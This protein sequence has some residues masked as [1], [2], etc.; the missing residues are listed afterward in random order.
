MKHILRLIVWS[1][2]LLVSTQSALATSTTLYPSDDTYINGNASYV[3]K[4]YGSF[5]TLRVSG[6]P[7]KN[8]AMLFKFP[9]DSLPANKTISSAKF[10]LY[11]RQTLDNTVLQSG[12]ISF[13]PITSAWSQDSVTWS[14]RPSVNIG[15]VLSGIR[16]IVDTDPGYQEWDITPLVQQW[17]DHPDQN[18]GFMIES[19]DVGWSCGL[20]SFEGAYQPKL[21]VQY[22][23]SLP[24]FIKPAI[25]IIPGFIVATP[26]PMPLP[27][28]QPTPSPTPTSTSSP[29]P[30]PTV[31]P[32]IPATPW[33]TTQP[34][35]SPVPTEEMEDVFIPVTKPE[36]A[37]NLPI[38]ILVTVAIFCL[39]GVI[40][41]ITLLRKRKPYVRTAP[42]KQR[43]RK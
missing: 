33:P 3:F 34:N 10:K 1:F 18:F 14:N 7:Q 38:M 30:T 26:T 9:V 20:D 35:T 24:T 2:L 37:T 31:K 22:G 16:E 6:L 36:S 11:Y 25:N 13:T 41:I 29:S 21:V 23:L 17:V 15:G 19:L 43:G 42:T 39:I 8:I 5:P 12:M 40:I 32:I 4:N 28:L 27:S